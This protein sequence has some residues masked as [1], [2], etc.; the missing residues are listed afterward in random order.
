MPAGRPFK[1]LDALKIEQ[2]AMVGCSN[3]EI[4][5]VLDVSAD[6]IERNYAG[7]IKAGK[8][9]RNY[10]LRKLQYEAAKRGNIVMQIW[11]G[12]QWLGQKDRPE[13]DDKPDVLG[14]LLVEYRKR[15]EILA[16]QNEEQADQGEKRAL[17][18]AALHGNR[19]RLRLPAR[20]A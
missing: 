1:Q 3:E 15:Y 19:N 16:G 10:N 18:E 8:A 13:L 7:A 14:E 4:A 9:A 2:M 11:L 17:R 20:P 12:K 6:T 5:L